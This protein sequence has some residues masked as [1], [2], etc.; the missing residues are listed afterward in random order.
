MI[1]LAPRAAE[2]ADDLR[3]VIPARSEADEPAIHLAAL[4]M[5]RVEAANAWL[6]ER[7]IFADDRGTPQPVLRA[8]STWENS[9]ARLL[10]RLG[11]T[12]T[13]RARLGLNIAQARRGQALR[14]HLAANYP[15]AQT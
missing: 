6:D 2:I 12:P 10:D 15:D 13:A 5:A 3:R 1:T 8:L 4:L 7:G 14:E 9:L 11:C